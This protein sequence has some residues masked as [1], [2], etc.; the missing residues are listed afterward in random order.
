[1]TYL[2][3]HS[4]FTGNMKYEMTTLATPHSVVK[5]VIITEPQLS[6][7]ISSNV[8]STVNGDPVPSDQ[9]EAKEKKNGLMNKIRNTRV[10]LFHS[11]VV[12]LLTSHFRITSLIVF[13]KN[14][15]T[16]RTSRKIKH[17]NRSIVRP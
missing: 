17:A 1:M 6:I 7:D 10:S 15:R 8:T 9:E 14:T 3:V 2:G 12:H 13:L 16:R 5:P 4:N 11:L